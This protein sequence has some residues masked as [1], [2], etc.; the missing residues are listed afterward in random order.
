MLGYAQSLSLIDR[1]R[2]VWTHL[3]PFIGLTLL[4]LASVLPAYSEFKL[5]HQFVCFYMTVALLRL[6]VAQANFI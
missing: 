3:I 6:S 1:V 2:D 4:S 5:R